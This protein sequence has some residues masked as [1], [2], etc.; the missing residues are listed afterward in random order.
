MHPLVAQPSCVLLPSD[1]KVRTFTGDLFEGL[2]YLHK[3][4]IMHR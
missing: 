1:A 2:A 4:G 3:A